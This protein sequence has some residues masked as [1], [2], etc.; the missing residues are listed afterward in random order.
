M[1][2]DAIKEAADK[3]GLGVETLHE[4]KSVGEAFDP[5]TVEKLR[6]ASHQIIANALDKRQA[7]ENGWEVFTIAVSPPEGEDGRR[8]VAS[9]GV[10]TPAVLFGEAL[11]IGCEMGYLPAIFAAQFLAQVAGFGSQQPA[12]DGSDTTVVLGGDDE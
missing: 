12:A 11:K 2:E 10:M 6:T 5:A 4:V 3:H 9:A 1:N 8:V 7:G